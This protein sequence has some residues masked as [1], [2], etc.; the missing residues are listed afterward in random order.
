MSKRKVEL[1]FETERVILRGS[2]PKASWCESCGSAALTVSIE[3]AA[4]LARTDELTLSRLIASGRL[5]GSPAENF[6][7][8]LCL[9]SLAT[10]FKDSSSSLEGSE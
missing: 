1:T 2:Q 4:T 8:C 9:D 5:H 7:L 3:Q 10:I 6:R